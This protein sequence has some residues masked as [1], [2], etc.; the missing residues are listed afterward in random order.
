MYR[1]KSC[2]NLGLEWLL[3]RAVVRRKAV[4]VLRSARDRIARG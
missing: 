2:A 4:V 1:S 3:G